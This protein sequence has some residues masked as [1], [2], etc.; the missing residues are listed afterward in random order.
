M[1]AGPTKSMPRLFRTIATK[2]MF[3]EE[4]PPTIR[5]GRLF[6]FIVDAHKR[7]FAL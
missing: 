5:R 6:L 2:A 7:D 4:H 1:I 3:A